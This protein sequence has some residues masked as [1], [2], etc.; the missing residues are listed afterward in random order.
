M[1]CSTGEVAVNIVASGVADSPDPNHP[2]PRRRSAHHRFKRAR[3]AARAPPSRSTRRCALLQHHLRGDRRYPAV[4]TGDA[5][6]EVKESIVGWPRT[7]RVPLEQIRH[8]RRL[9]G[10]RRLRPPEFPIRVLRNNV[11]IFEGALESLKRFKDDVNEVRAGT[12]RH[13]PWKNYSDVQETIRSNA[14][15]SRG[16]AYSFR[17]YA[18]TEGRGAQA[19]SNST[20]V[21][22]R[23]AATPTDSARPQVGTEDIW[24]KTIR[25]HGG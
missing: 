20:A 22:T 5:L 19:P 3:D 25:A 12:M 15:A 13:R 8:G 11:V 24:R 4:L 10:H 1:P 14:I 7:Q 18:P 2:G 6:P 17:C 21:E 23:V 16:G 9:H